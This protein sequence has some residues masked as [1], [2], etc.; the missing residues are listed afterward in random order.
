VDGYNHKFLDVWVDES[1][2]L[3]SPV[4]LAS[5]GSQ[6]APSPTASTPP[7]DAAAAT[8]VAAA[9]PTAAAAVAAAVPTGPPAADGPPPLPLLHVLN[10]VA[11]GNAVATVP[12]LVTERTS[13][14]CASVAAYVPTSISDGIVFGKTLPSGSRRGQREELTNAAALWLPDVAPEPKAFFAAAE[15]TCLGDGFDTAG[16]ALVVTAPVNTTGAGATIATSAAEVHALRERGVDGVWATLDCIAEL[17]SSSADGTAVY[18][19]AAAAIAKIDSYLGPSAA[20]PDH[21]RVGVRPGASANASASTLPPAA[22]QLPE[23]MREA[24]AGA[25]HF[26]KLLRAVPPD[27]NGDTRFADFCREY[28]DSVATDAAAVLPAELRKL[29]L[30]QPPGDLL[31]RRFKHFSQVIRTEPLPTRPSPTAP[32][33]GWWPH[34][35]EDIVERWALLEIKQWYID[36]CAWHK[37]GGIASQRPAARAYGLD[38][39]KPIARGYPW[40][41]R[42]GEGNIKLMDNATEPVRSCLQREK[43]AA[44]FNGCIDQELTSMLQSGVEFKCDLPHQIVLMPNLLSLYLDSGIDAAAAQM[45]DMAAAGW[46]GI[47]G[48]TLP[49]IPFRCIPRG[50]VHKKGVAELRGIADHG[51]PRKRL[52]T[53]RSGE[54]VPALNDV[55]RLGDWHHE[56][57][58]DVQA[59]VLN[60]LIVQAL[61]DL[62]NEPVIDI[63]LDWSKWYH[64]LWYH[65][66]ELWQMGA[67]VPDIGNG[68]AL[69]FAIEYVMTMGARPASQIAQRLATTMVA[70]LC[71]EFD[72]MER[73]RWQRPDHDGLSAEA[74]A[75]LDARELLRPDASFGSQAKMYSALMY[76][77]DLEASI[78]G[79]ERALRFL[80]LLFDRVGPDGLNL[81]LSR[82]SK[83]QGG[84]VKVWLGA[85][86]STSMG[87]CWTPAEKAARALARIEETLDGSITAGKYRE[88][89]GLLVHL[90]FMIGGDTTLLHHIFRPFRRGEEMDTGGPAAIVQVDPLMR[91]VLRRWHFAILNQPGCAAAAAASPT[92][93]SPALRRH[94]VR[95]D[96][97]L[98]GTEAPGLGGWYDGEWWCVPLSSDA[99]LADLDIPHLEF[100]ASCVAILVWA[101][102]LERAELVELETDALAT[103]FALSERTRSP[104]MQV[105]LDALLARA[106]YKALARRLIITACMGAGNPLADA[107]SRGYA[108]TLSIISGALGFVPRKVELPAEAQQFLS[109]ALDKL[110]ALRPGGGLGSTALSSGNLNLKGDEPIAHGGDSE[111]AAPPPPPPSPPLPRAPSARASPMA[112]APPSP[113][114][115]AAAAPSRRP[116]PAP[117]SPSQRVAAPTA[118]TAPA[119]PA[120][121]PPLPHHP[122]TAGSPMAMSP[123]PP[124]A[125][126]PSTSSEAPPAP[127]FPPSAASSPAY[128]V[129]SKRKPTRSPPVTLASPPLPAI[130]PRAPSPGFRMRPPTPPPKALLAKK[131]KG[132]LHLASKLRGIRQCVAEG[133]L[134][135]LRTDTSEHAIGADDAD[136]EWLASLATVG[137]VDEMALTSKSQLESN[138]KH[139]LAFC[140]RFKVTPLRP[141]LATLDVV[142][143]RREKIIWTAAL[144]W[145]YVYSMKP[146]RGKFLS[147]G[148]PKPVSPE[149]AMA[150]LRGVRRIHIEAGVDTPPLKTAMK[151]LLELM[152]LYAKDVGP[153]NVAPQRKAPLTHALI[154]AMLMVPEDTLFGGRADREGPAGRGAPWTWLTPYGRSCKTAIHVLAQCGFR[155]AEI[156]LASGAKFDKLRFSFANLTWWFDGGTRETATP[157]LKDLLTLRKG[158][159]CGVIPPPSKADQFGAKWANNTIWLPF[160]ATAP[161]NAARALA[162]WEIVARVAPEQ[163]RSTPL[164]CGPSGVGSSLSAD[165]F[166]TLFHRLLSTVIGPEAASK[167]SVHSFRSY[168]ASAMVAAGCSDGEVQAALRWA[169][170]DALKVYKVANKETYAGWLIRAE[171]VKLTGVRL[172]SMPRPPPEYDNEERAAAIL[173]SAATL[174]RTATAGDAEDVQ[175]S[176]VAAA[177]RAADAGAAAARAARPAR[178]AVVART[179]A[180]ALGATT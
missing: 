131:V 164:F 100:L 54:E 18:R 21:T 76:T 26:V 172:A 61:A 165:A 29:I 156:A 159:Y 99:R 23:R 44:F 96:A 73:E 6:R 158:D 88:L 169:S 93:W 24:E 46:L 107:A 104:R 125:P 170:E 10:G 31:R 180:P 37:G 81:P 97:A 38:A 119:A 155:K 140:A 117:A 15:V 103:A 86:I 13:G 34:S 22:K 12:V 36:C 7:P 150:V 106:A 39:I 68:G 101:R 51:N 126:L 11:R 175:H 56:D 27:G 48:Q 151:R 87:V 138:W 69:A 85:A 105:I 130:P 128:A 25:L 142:G 113:G 153:E 136:L 173:T 177:R 178:A 5:L 1:V 60:G 133:V 137:E 160:S 124:T 114:L 49:C 55:A 90:L 166:S 143:V 98:L 89:L 57:K 47:F 45:G 94:R 118:Q 40:D 50:E 116:T 28:A 52:R 53:Q 82:A 152:R 144:A 43:A 139:W 66:L 132:V 95:A 20:M 74:R 79:P 147:D 42:G 33:N 154:T 78:S 17:T 16:S 8:V 161:I 123:P 70:K 148:R 121:S 162:Q 108:E 2:L 102:R 179:V 171:R 141:D 146:A 163:R 67:L 19:V 75:A 64:R 112:L 176:A 77:D 65:A 91:G 4:L 168:L 157:Q 120:P 84:L 14:G 41:L 174:V 71:E 92:A 111:P 167:Y 83:Q 145:I 134:E 30:P 135:M 63:A 58:D 109:D 3:A 129:P 80:R 9:A 149:S 59:A 122:G 32:P 72:R 115:P 110:A 127:P 62:N 35:I